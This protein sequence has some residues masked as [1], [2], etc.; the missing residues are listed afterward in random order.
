MQY[1]NLELLKE[2]SF[3][4]VGSRTPT[5][6]GK[7]YCNK[8]CKE[9]TLRD[10]PIVSGMAVGIDTIAHQTALKNGGKTIAVLPC[11]IN[12]IY[13]KENEK[14]FK[15]IIENDGLVITEYENDEIAD[16][17]RFLERNRLVVALG[18]GLFVV[19]ALYRSGT[20]VTARIAT[21]NN[22]KVF[23]L[24][25]SL[26]NTYSHGTNN[27]IK[28]GAY[29]VMDAKDIFFQ[30]PEFFSRQIKKSKKIKSIGNSDLQNIYNALSEE[31]KSIDKIALMTKTNIREVTQKLIL[32]EIDGIVIHEIGKGF[33]I[34]G[35]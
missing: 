23:A 22:K 18:E 31:P 30:F 2:Q 12:N 10:I 20:S 21:E 1:G 5:E 19:E 15:Q 28:N 14:L 9:I 26:D 25:G 34:K 7:K 33:K 8:I 35:E 13:P 17:K 24:P 16:S 6:Y 4:V 32:M 3:S 29:L 11:G 27:L